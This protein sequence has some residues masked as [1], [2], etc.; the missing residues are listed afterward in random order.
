MTTEE[1]SETA[2]TTEA[3]EENPGILQGLEEETTRELETVAEKFAEEQFAALSGYKRLHA[4][5]KFEPGKPVTIAGGVLATVAAVGG[6]GLWVDNVVRTFHAEVSRWD[7]AAAL[8]AILPLVGCQVQ[9]AAAEEHGQLDLLDHDL[10]V[11]ADGLMMTGVGLIPGL[12]VQAFRS[13]RSTL[14][15]KQLPSANDLLRLRDQKWQDHLGS[16]NK[17]LFSDDFASLVEADLMIEMSTALYDATNTL[18]R[19]QAGERVA[20]M[21]GSNTEQVQA[22]QAGML[23][24]RRQFVQGVN[25]RKAKLRT[26]LP[27]RMKRDSNCAGLHLTTS[28]PYNGLPSRGPEFGNVVNS[29]SCLS[30]E[31]ASANPPAERVKD[32]DNDRGSDVELTISKLV[33]PALKPSEEGQTCPFEDRNKCSGVEFCIHPYYKGC[34]RVE[35]SLGDCCMASLLSRNQLFR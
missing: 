26:N 2:S 11:F 14:L 17:S 20:L 16:M 31:P 27:T 24:I 35:G 18:G 10:C 9:A 29:F 33:Q 1:V 23:E 30:N 4:T 25:S 8:T 3:F 15:G 5:T 7:K 34:R 32:N 21:A 28:Y 19:L 12:A 22:I 13:I 6:F